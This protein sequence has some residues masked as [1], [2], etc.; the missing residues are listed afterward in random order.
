MQR[1]NALR[2]CGGS[3]NPVCF[4][5]TGFFIDHFPEIPNRASKGGSYG[6]LNRFNLIYKQDVPTEH[7]YKYTIATL[8]E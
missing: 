4:V 2:F 6:A 1:R 5:Q 3:T 8:D 7:L